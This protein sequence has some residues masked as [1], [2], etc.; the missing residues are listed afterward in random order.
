MAMMPARWAR[1][2]WPMPHRRSSVTVPS[3]NASPVVVPM[4]ESRSGDV[5]LISSGKVFDRSGMATVQKPLA[6]FP[7]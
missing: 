3:F 1:Q 6:G 7:N 2:L 4:Q 5:Q